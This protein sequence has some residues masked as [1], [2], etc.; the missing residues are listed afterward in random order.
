VGSQAFGIA[1]DI[2]H[3]LALRRH[4]WPGHT[5]T[6]YTRRGFLDRHLTKE[7]RI[8]SC[9]KPVFSIQIDG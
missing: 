2:L 4:G 7:T 1:T 6:L 9:W 5:L 3:V 8:V